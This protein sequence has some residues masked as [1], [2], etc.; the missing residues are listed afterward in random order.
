M[1]RGEAAAN[2]LVTVVAMTPL[3][4]LAWRVIPPVAAAARSRPGAVSGAAYPDRRRCADRGWLGPDA[5]VRPAVACRAR[6]I[7]P[8]RG[9]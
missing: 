9:G 6:M 4:L 5:L 8:L 7:V 3:M 2:L 1:S